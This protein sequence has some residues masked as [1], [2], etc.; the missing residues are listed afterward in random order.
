M[1]LAN[2]EAKIHGLPVTEVHL[3]E[4]GGVDTVVDTVGVAAALHSLG[5]TELWSAPLRLGAGQTTSAHGLIPVPAPATLELLDGVP[6]V[7]ID[8]TFE[9]VTPTGVAMLRAA[10]CR[11]G[12]MPAM[13]VGA[14]GYGAGGRDTE[15]RPNVLPA[16]SGVA[17][18]RGQDPEDCL[19]TMMLIETT[20]DDVTG[21]V[22]GQLITRLF[23]QGAADAWIAS[24]IGKKNRPA[25]VVTALCHI[26]D[27]SDIETVLLTETGSLGSRRQTI[28]RRAL[29]RR[30]S[31]IVVAG[32]PVRV[33]S[34]PHH[35]KPEFED[36]LAVSRKSGLPLR[37]VTNLALAVLQS[38]K[39]DDSSAD[40]AGQFRDTSTTLANGAVRG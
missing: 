17:P 18:N 5:V 38:L 29:P 26:S 40:Q 15:D 4:L 16:A 37:V 13:S 23:E 2:A 31:E 7:G 8:S 6:A 27:I 33:K 34:G 9:T 19:E 10:G 32:L 39:S 20:V 35:H 11:F 3:H 21:E 14:A 36:L 22:L 25:H 28:E 1:L 30:Q 24:V 12:P